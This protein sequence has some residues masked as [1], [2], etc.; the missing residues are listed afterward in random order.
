MNLYVHVP[1]CISKCR[2]CAFYSTVGAAPPLLAEYPRLLAGELELRGCR[3][4][5]PD[6]MY[7][8]G[9][10]PSILGPEG[11]QALFSVLPTPAPGAEITLEVNPGDVTAELAAAMRGCGVTRVSLGAQS[12]DPRTLQFLGRRHTADENRGAVSAL[13]HAGFDDMS[14]DLIAAIPGTPRGAFR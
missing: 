5:R 7:I 2:Y 11:V 6:T 1:F 8:G 12:F 3:G 10:T 13:R 14:L 9:G 4:A